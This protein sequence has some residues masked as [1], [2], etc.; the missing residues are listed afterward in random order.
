V[1]NPLGKDAVIFP[2]LMESFLDP[3]NRLY[4]SLP[5]T[6]LFQFGFLYTAFLSIGFLGK[7]TGQ[8]CA[9]EMVN[10]PY[11]DTDCPLLQRRIGE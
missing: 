8:L 7:G 6:I 3:V 4:S 1:S 10:I 5:F 11:S 9:G 2:Q